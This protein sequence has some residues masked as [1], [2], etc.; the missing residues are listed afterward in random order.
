MILLGL[1]GLAFILKTEF[2]IKLLTGE[3]GVIASGIDGLRII[4]FGFLFYAMGM[5]MSQAFNGAGDTTTPTWM[6]FIAFWCLE[7]PIA[8]FLAMKAG[9]DQHGVYMAIVIGEAVLT[10]MG[11]VLFRRGK[12][13]ERK[14]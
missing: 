5:V 2:F 8:Y 11:V 9:F 6:N 7:I 4:S 14:V 12:W 1:F 10:I 3:V 13:K